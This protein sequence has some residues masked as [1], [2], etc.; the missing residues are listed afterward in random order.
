M[1]DYCESL[2]NKTGGDTLDRTNKIVRFFYC[3]TAIIGVSLSLSGGVM[4]SLIDKR[5]YDTIYAEVGHAPAEEVHAVASVFLN[6]ADKQGYEKALKGSSAY[7]KQSKEYLKASTG[8]MNPFEKLTYTRNKQII[9]TLIAQPKTRLP[10]THFENVN[11][12]G[13]PS[14]AKGAIKAQ[15]IGRQRFYLLKE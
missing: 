4:G 11:A 9:D 8:K 1:K 14:W 7:N 10:Y 6:R 2:T 12:F 15:D 5:L 3:L 13:I